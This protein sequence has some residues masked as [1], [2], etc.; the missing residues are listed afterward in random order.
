MAEACFEIQN[1][2]DMLDRYGDNGTGDIK[3]HSGTDLLIS[4]VSGLPLTS[5]QGL[6]AMGAWGHPL[7]I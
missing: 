6:G 3:C 7:E 4:I 1:R 2:Q 5:K